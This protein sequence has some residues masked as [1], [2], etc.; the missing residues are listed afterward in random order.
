MSYFQ[1]FPN[2]NFYNQDLGWL[3]KKYK[4]LNGDVKILQQIYDMIKEQIKDITIEQLK[5]W[6]DD[7]TLEQLINETLFTN[8]NQRRWNVLYPP[9]GYE[10]LVN[11][12]KFD[13]TNRL[14]NL[15]NAEIPLFFPEGSY[16][17]QS[18]I[19]TN[20]K[21]NILGLKAKFISINGLNL[22]LDLSSSE[23]IYMKNIEFNEC[24]YNVYPAND[25][26]KDLQFKM[27]HKRIIIENCPC[28]GVNQSKTNFSKLIVT[29][30]PKD[31]TRDFKDG[32]FAHYPLQIY[33]AS[34]YN[35]I[36][37]ENGAFDENGSIVT[38]TDNSAIGIV[39]FHNGGTPVLFIDMWGNRPMLQ[40]KNR[41]AVITSEQKPGF[42]FDMDKNG[43]IAIGCLTY[44]SDPCAPYSAALKIRDKIPIITLINSNDKTLIG[45][46]VLNDFFG[47]SRKGT[48]FIK[49]DG[50]VLSTENQY[51]NELLF[52]NN[53]LNAN[54]FIDED[55][56]IRCASVSGQKPT[57]GLHLMRNN[58]GNNRPSNLTNSY[59]DIG[60]MYFDATLN[61]PI[62]WD[63]TK[64]I[65]ATGSAV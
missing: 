24:S 45:S 22:I 20:K 25:G 11:D 17:F 26:L 62:W 50:S 23:N 57:T 48:Y 16:N 36:D 5:E 19:I 15:L 2:T 29:P 27:R 63:G 56:Y 51:F 39:D 59:K 3:I 33:N 42:V 31:Y 54:I 64:W 9:T 46:I 40:F 58:N 4:E 28:T 6:L 38:T 21:I 60:F 12:G 43:H 37:I 52:K 49:F 34:G 10:P 44:S 18:A 7:G 47:L 14:L 32:R 1:S 55:N 13:N 61:K 65:D 53:V 41:Q 35:A 30:K 8:L